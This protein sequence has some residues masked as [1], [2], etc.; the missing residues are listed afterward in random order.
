MQP[1]TQYAKSG[2]LNIAYQVVGE[3]PIDLVFTFGWASHLDFQWTDPTFTR[4]LRRL[5]R[6]A[7]VIVFDK[8]GVGLSDPVPRPPTIEER[9]DDIRAVMDAAGSQSAALIGYSEGGVMSAL[10]AA[11]HPERTRALV[12]Y[13]TWVC[14]LLDPLENPGGE[15]W[16][17]VD[18][19]VRNAIEHWGEGASLDLVAPS[20]SSSALD[21]R[22][23]GTFERAAMSPGMA[24]ALWES[25]VEVDIRPVLPTISVPTLI[26]HHTGSHIP[27]ENAHYAARHV[28]GARFVELDGIDHAP[29]THDADRIAG[30]IEEF[31]T[32]A[33]GPAEPDRV[34]A[35]VLFTDIVGSTDRAAALGDQRWLALLERHDA[36]VRKEL[37]RFHGREVKHTGDGF[38]AT[39]DGPARAIRC[40]TAVRD[41][42]AGLDIDIRSGLHTGEC[43]R[44]GDDVGGM[45]IH[46]AARVMARAG[47]GE[48]LVSSTV[49]DLVYGS[50]IEFDA[51]GSHELKG[52]EGEWAL[53]AVRGEQGTDDD[54]P[55]AE[56]APVRP[57]LNDRMARTIARRTPG[58]ARAA[59]GLRR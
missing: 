49:K 56:L 11:A 36:A 58:L 29:F 25:F 37:Q 15:R 6:F 47:D 48:V 40:A 14:G 30:E 5:A 17:Q 10:F 12:M 26:V 34:L 59:A 4:F 9:M 32:G 51:R 20:L 39:F 28:P 3:G 45:A 22:L 16:M 57:T 43:E 8:R 52:A 53:F 38:L 55:M 46:I 27:V 31:L 7:R 19:D 42:L 21:R 41:E 33:R 50:G 54:E 24:K 44:V 18:R 2:D 1:K 23:Y 35:T 13:E